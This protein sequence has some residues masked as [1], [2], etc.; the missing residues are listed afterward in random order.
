MLHKWIQYIVIYNTI[1]L[2]LS[3]TS[4]QEYSRK[5]ANPKSTT[6]DAISPHPILIFSDSPIAFTVYRYRVFV[7]SIDRSK[8]KKSLAKALTNA[9]VPKVQNLGYRDRGSEWMVFMSVGTLIFVLE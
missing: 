7:K 5:E 3:I 4:L 8:D 6:P 2:F 9:I 1:R